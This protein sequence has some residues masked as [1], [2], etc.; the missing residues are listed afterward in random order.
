MSC[1]A[2]S[3]VNRRDDNRFFFRVA[4]SCDSTSQPYF[5]S[6]TLDQCH[7]LTC[8]FVNESDVWKICVE[9]GDT[10][11]C[12]C[13]HVNFAEP[14]ELEEEEEKEADSNDGKEV[15]SKL[16]PAS[17]SSSGV[18]IFAGEMIDVIFHCSI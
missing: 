2:Y 3:A 18:L 12:L 16:L 17:S 9:C 8:S 14:V 11:W 4:V 13:G 1:F 7:S 10:I 5:D 6:Y 15:Y